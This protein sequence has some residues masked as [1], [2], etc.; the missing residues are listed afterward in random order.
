[1]SVKHISECM[2]LYCNELKR[3]ITIREKKKS[4]HKAA[5]LSTSAL[6]LGKIKMANIILKNMK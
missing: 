6:T 1:M 5:L 4:S 2:L 3:I